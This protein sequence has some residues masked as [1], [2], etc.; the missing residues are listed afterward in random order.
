[1]RR[2]DDR[3]LPVIVAALGV[4]MM[5]ALA[6]IAL[7]IPLRVPLDANEGWNAY[8][9]VEAFAGSLYAPP[10]PFFFNVYPPLSFYIV[11]AVASLTGDPIVAGRAIACVSFV[12]LGIL[13]S[14]AAGQM[15]CT[16]YEAA[17]GG[18]LFAASTLALSHYVGIDDPH[19]LGQAVVCAG[20]PFVLREPHTNARLWTAGALMTTGIFIKHSIVALPLTAVAWLWWADPPA[21][22]RLL[23][24]GFVLATVSLAAGFFWYGPAFHEALVTSRGYSVAVALRAVARW[25]I[26]VP[27][28]IAAL[29]LLVRR[30]PRDRHVIFCVCY[31][32]TASVAGL[33]FL[34]G[35]GVDWNAMFESNWACALSAAVAVN[36]LTPA[37]AP[38][39]GGRRRVALCA[40]FV[41]MPMAAMALGAKRA[42]LAPDYWLRP[43]VEETAAAARDV[44][45]IAGR[46]GPAFCE[47]LALCFWAGK[48]PEVDVFNL[49]QRVRHDASA[50]EALLRLVD[51]RHYGVVQ[52]NEMAPL[53]GPAFLDAL[54][55][56]YIIIASRPASVVLA[57]Q[58]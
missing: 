38:G 40:A 55:R 48:P 28:L 30:C 46:P 42:W 12:A 35:A 9:S 51:D 36:R 19:F 15:G 49:Q 14:R 45:V 3:S 43:R 44:T 41:A 18:V 58:P 39:G 11:H 20:L 57:P 23:T 13:L 26:R 47:D 17:F 10:S 54:N 52:L 37:H 50:R 4:A 7:T 21:G 25:I 32:V 5:P 16:R 53:F 6:R 34:G 56:R 22:R 2:Q 33:L 29:V 1:V 24:A 8:H 27:V 31:V